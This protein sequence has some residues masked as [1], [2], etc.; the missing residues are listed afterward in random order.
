MRRTRDLLRTRL[1]LTDA[2][3]EKVERFVVGARRP[4]S[5]SLHGYRRASTWTRR[6]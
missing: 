4:W 1:S 6:N 5:R 2:E 3:V